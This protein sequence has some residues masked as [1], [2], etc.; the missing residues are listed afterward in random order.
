M[1]IVVDTNIVFSAMLNTNSHIARIILQP[2]TGF[3]FYST[4]Q[5]LLEIEEHSERIMVLSG[6]NGTEYKKVFEI[7]T[8]KIRFINVNLIPEDLYRQALLLT[9][10]IDVDDTEFVALTEHIKGKLWSGD[11]SLLSGITKKGWRKNIST[12]ELLKKINLKKL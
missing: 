4:E 6:Y 5:L 11:K 3:N 7:V 12:K 9:E 10:D 8:R 2:K 1:R